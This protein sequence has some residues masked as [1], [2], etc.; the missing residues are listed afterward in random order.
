MNPVASAR[1]TLALSTG[2]LA[3]RTVRLLRIGGGTSLPGM[4]ARRIDP[5]VLRKVIGRTRAA[6]L[7]VTGSNGKTTTC[8]MIAAIATAAG[9]GVVQNRTG[10]N[11]LQGVTSV[12]VTGA[13]LFGEMQADVLLFEIDEATMSAAAAE[14]RPGVVIVTNIFRD[15]LDRFGELYAVAGALER[16][17]TA[18]PPSATAILN[19]DD[20]LVASFAPDAACRR[21]Y[22]GMQTQDVGTE[23]PEHA[24][25][26]IRC[27]R[28]QHDL[29]YTKVYISHLGDFRCPSCGY[30]RPRLDVAVTAV[31]PGAQGS[32]VTLAT[33]DGEL[34]FD[35]GLPGL[36]NVYNAAAAVAATRAL[37]LAP[38][39][40]PSAMASLRPAFGRL[41][42]IAA[43]DK[44]V[45]LGFVKNPISYNT[46][47]RTILQR[48]GPKAILAV[49]SNTVVD[50]EDFAWLWDVDLEEAAAQVPWVVAGGTKADEVA[51]RFKYAGIPEAR[52]TVERELTPAL[53]AALTRTPPG[54]TLYILSGYTPTRELRR[55]ME[56]RGWVK[57]FWED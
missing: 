35:V 55:I 21:I 9:K 53:D 43:G 2:K 29:V 50:G 44:Q 31:T 25:D 52:I 18:L 12:A 27:V 36:H 32:A 33:P 37:G 49:H 13:N 34:R 26:T 19:G 5:L 54:G 20:P 3:G 22:F 40:I 15:Q 4:V 1:L 30:A 57:P 24:A 17:I 10:S 47:L 6:K 48:P 38:A 42:T 8:R 23:V 7:V 28:C 16:A 51:M 56:S 14:I 11:L 41:E 45:V 39:G 46:T